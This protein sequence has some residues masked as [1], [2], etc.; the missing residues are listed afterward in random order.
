MVLVYVTG[1]SGTGKSLIRRELEERGYTA[2]G[3]DENG[4]A[5]WIDRSSGAVAAFPHDDPELD[6]ADW[7]RRHSWVFSVERVAKL[8][9]DADAAGQTVFLCGVAERD[10]TVWPYFDLVI[11]LVADAVTITTRLAERTGNDFGKSPEQLAEV[12]GWHRHYARD[13]RRFGA[14][15]VD[16]TRPIDEV[17]A[18]VLAAADEVPRAAGR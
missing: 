6:F 14:R 4:Y 10:D 11:A 8:R 9:R 1:L 16:A 12:L 5:D 3:V 15:L 17:V 13:Y 7:Y 2:H 18:A